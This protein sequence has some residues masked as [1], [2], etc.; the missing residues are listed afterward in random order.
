MLTVITTQ[1]TMNNPL[2][3]TPDSFDNDVVYLSINPAFEL[4]LR[5]LTIKL[6]M[7]NN[8]AD[9]Y[10]SAELDKLFKGEVF[11]TTPRIA[12]V[13]NEYLIKLMTND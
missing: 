3:I 10:I 4:H 1:V 2:L 8:G 6:R 12:D 7:S 13:L 11:S 5:V 9:K